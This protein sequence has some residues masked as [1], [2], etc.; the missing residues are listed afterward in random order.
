MPSSLSLTGQL[1]TIVKKLVATGRYR[2]QNDVIRQGI[3]LVEEQEKRRAA[4]DSAIEAGISDADT[5]RVHLAE[6][7]FSELRSRYESLIETQNK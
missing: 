5:G 6:D 7:V 3:L 2:S 4:L 1:E